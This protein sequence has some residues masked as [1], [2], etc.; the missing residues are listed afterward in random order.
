MKSNCKKKVLVC[1]N[2][3]GGHD[4]FLAVDV[5]KAIGKVI[6]SAMARGGFIKLKV[7]VFQSP[8]IVYI[9]AVK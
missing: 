8:D 9:M 1:N 3:S 2:L 6:S 4:A 7:E 5:D